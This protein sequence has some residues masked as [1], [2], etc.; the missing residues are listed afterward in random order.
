MPAIPVPRFQYNDPDLKAPA[1]GR[2]LIFAVGLV[3]SIPGVGPATGGQHFGVPLSIGPKNTRLRRLHDN[4]EVT[5][6]NDSVTVWAAPFQVAG[7]TVGEYALS[8][9]PGW[10]WLRWTVADHVSYDNQQATAAIGPDPSEN[11]LVIIPCAA[12]KADR[13]AAARDLYIGSF[14]RMCYRAASALTSD[15]NIRILSAK[16]G[17]LRLNDQVN[18]YA[19]RMGDPGTVTVEQLIRQAREQEILDHPN[20][21]ILAGRDYTAMARHLWPSAATPLQGSRSIGE[22]RQRLAGIAREPHV[23]LRAA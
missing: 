10:H 6:P 23:S 11:P 1:P 9:R 16:H 14:H 5:L 8:N 22:H 17:L 19:L 3:E 21:V 20:V 13:P 12:T 4:V 18:P 2:E 15:D 7:H